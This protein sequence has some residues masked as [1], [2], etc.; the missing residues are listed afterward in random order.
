MIKQL[1]SLLDSSSSSLNR[2]S[3]RTKTFLMMIQ[4]EGENLLLRESQTRHHPLSKMEMKTE[5]A[6]RDTV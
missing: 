2:N 1:R 6:K 4:I 3:K 5:T